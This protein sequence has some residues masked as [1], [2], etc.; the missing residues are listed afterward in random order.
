MVNLA[1]V[2]ALLS[3]HT[4]AVRA[5]DFSSASCIFEVGEGEELTDVTCSDHGDSLSL[6][7]KR[8]Q[9]ATAVSR[10]I[11]SVSAEE[12]RHPA[13]A[14]EKAK[15]P[16]DSHMQ[17]SGGEVGVKKLEI[18]APAPH[19]D[20]ISSFSLLQDMVTYA[21]ARKAVQRLV[22]GV[23]SFPLLPILGAALLIYCVLVAIFIAPT[24]FG[25]KKDGEG[26][27]PGERLVMDQRPITPQAPVKSSPPIRTVQEPRN[28]AG[29]TV[30]TQTLKTER[31]N[32]WPTS[33]PPGMMPTSA[34]L[35]DPMSTTGSSQTGMPMPATMPSTMPATVQM[36][37]GPTSMLQRLTGTS[38]D[39]DPG[40][41]P[42]SP[43]SP[44]LAGMRQSALC[45]NVMLAPTQRLLFSAVASDSRMRGPFDIYWSEEK[46]SS[47]P[48]FRLYVRDAGGH[49]DKLDLCEVKPGGKASG[50]L[51]GSAS[52]GNIA[53]CASIGPNRPLGAE[54]LV[55]NMQAKSSTRGVSIR[56][57]KDLNDKI[58]S[59][60]GGLCMW[61]SV[62]SGV[63]TGDGWL[64]IGE[65]QYL[66]MA[67]NGVPVL[68]PSEPA[69]TSVGLNISDEN[70]ATFARLVPLGVGQYQVE[71]GGQ[72]IMV[73]AT[74]G[75]SSRVELKSGG[76]AQMAAVPH[77]KK[78]AMGQELMELILMAPVGVD[79][80]LS[81]LC[82]I[83]V[84]RRLVM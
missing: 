56:R 24:W 82:S 25:G 31:E 12:V 48:R 35:G 28:Y 81:I 76:G 14:L 19:G 66:P 11:K 17:A 22:I 3:F 57:S 51:F 74:G 30:W 36:R 77:A 1:L 53:P 69:Q 26:S 13:A 41:M 27:A 78:L 20:R 45:P 33:A 4:L 9:K 46:V 84:L 23:R 55:S 79:P 21:S 40:I 2:S 61:N 72:V 38:G 49:A 43:T 62:V 10:S 80:L 15:S 67:V 54:Y 42:G 29:R 32:S 39:R 63:E 83:A 64:K 52:G 60:A 75:V 59:E 44:Q 73:I 70:G 65:G 18:E 68:F 16:E 47:G 5:E 37:P 8:A 71:K 58:K 50:W 7:Q 6:V 34:P